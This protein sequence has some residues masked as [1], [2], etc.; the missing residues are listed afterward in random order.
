[1]S[2][3]EQAKEAFKDHQARKESERMRLEAELRERNLLSIN[4]AAN[5]PLIIDAVHRKIIDLIH[6]DGIT[7]CFLLGYSFAPDVVAISLYRGSP[8]PGINHLDE[9][10]IV[11]VK[12]NCTSPWFHDTMPSKLREGLV[13]LGYT[14][15]REEVNKISGWVR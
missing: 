3:I 15:T 12:V 8:F 4:T 7:S 9:D 6:Q 13:G 10:F 11:T 1:M 2:G 14:I 5:M